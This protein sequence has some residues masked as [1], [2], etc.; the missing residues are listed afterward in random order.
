L[1]LAGK[2]LTFAEYFGGNH[3]ILLQTVAKWLCIK[4]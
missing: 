4:L 1:A 2:Q 3:V